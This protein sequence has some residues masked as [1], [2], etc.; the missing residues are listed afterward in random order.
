MKKKDRRPLLIIAQIL[1][2]Y[3]AL[4]VLLYLCERG[5]PGSQIN[6]IWDA[7]WYSFVTLSSVGYGDITP[8]TPAGYLIGVFFLIMAMGLLVALIGSVVSF[9]QSE[10]LPMLT[11]R[12]SRRKNWY[13]ISEF[14]AEADAL[15]QD[16]LREDS[17]GIIIFGVS[18]DELIER[19]DYPCLF[20]SSSPSKIVAQKKGAG[21]RCKMF[22]LKEND[23][24]KNPK[25]VNLHALPVD[26]YAGTTSGIDKMP[27]NIHFFHTYDCCARSYWREHPLNKEDNSIVIIG[28]GNYGQALL[29][30][31]I[32]TNINDS[33]FDVSYHVFGDAA[34]FLTIHDRLDLAFGINERKE[35]FDSIYFHK[36]GW[37]SAHDVISRADRIIIC[38]DDE[39]AGWDAMWQIQRYYKA[40]G[41]IYLR[42]NR[43]APGVRYFGTNE[44]IY[45]VNQIVRTRLNDAAV[46]MNDLYR[47][48]VED[49]LDWDDLSDQ[50]KQSKIAAADH[51][52]MKVRILLKEGP[53]STLDWENCRAAYE[54]YCKAKEDPEML[55]RLRRIEH[56]RWARFYVYN[57]WTYG[58]KRNEILHQ[59]PMIR[60]YDNLTEDQKKYHDRAWELL[61]EISRQLRK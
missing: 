60:R 1:L 13:Y 6:S 16:I 40:R 23:I 27:G 45:T 35:G 39:P 7:F 32:L 14:S 38:E 57:N 26:V 42:S 19:P 53:V 5:Q 44:Q 55:D 37:E 25:A 48:S 4:L 47:K 8:V 22:F 20:I 31:A 28:F 59:S 36:E 12:L 33:D 50:L 43:V 3:I 21:E 56:A 49:S 18:R 29:E 9:L 17:D 10:G 24:G 46:A 11:L 15:A 30:R 61:D 52:F 51:L 2:V 41:Y 54:N 34:R 58:P